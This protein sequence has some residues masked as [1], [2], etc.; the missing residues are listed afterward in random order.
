MAPFEQQACHIADEPDTCT[1]AVTSPVT[2]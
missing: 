2:F 1:L